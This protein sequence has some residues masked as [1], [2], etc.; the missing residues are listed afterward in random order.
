M[1]EKL[2]SFLNAIHS[3][4]LMIMRIDDLRQEEKR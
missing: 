2:N 1:R 4:R 3:N